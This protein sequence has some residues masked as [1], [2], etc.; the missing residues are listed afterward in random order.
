MLQELIEVFEKVCL[1]TALD[2]DPGQ[3]KVVE[4]FPPGLDKGNI[5]VY[6]ELVAVELF[7]DELPLTEAPML[8]EGQH[9]LLLY[10]VLLPVKALFQLPPGFDELPLPALD[11]V[12]QHLFDG[13]VEPVGGRAGIP[14][15]RGTYPKDPACKDTE[16]CIVPFGEL[17]ELLFG[18]LLHQRL[19]GEK[20]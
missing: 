7:I 4:L 12:V 6:P 2:D 19:A 18:E 11:I 10:G 20:G 8:H 17:L 16:I 14:V 5:G 13:V 9:D 1:W 3:L 15:A